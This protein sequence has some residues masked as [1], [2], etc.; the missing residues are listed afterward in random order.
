MIF[1]KRKKK[2]NHQWS[3]NRLYNNMQVKYEL[4]TNLP[5]LKIVTDCHKIV[6]KW[7]VIRQSCKTRAAL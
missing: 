6:L 7:H 4:A 5:K 2:P 1:R 3:G